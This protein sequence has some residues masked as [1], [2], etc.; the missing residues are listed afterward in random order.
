MTSAPKE[1]MGVVSALTNISRTTGFS[2][3]IAT[4]TSLFTILLGIF[5]LTFVYDVA[6]LNAYQMTAWLFTI[7]VIIAMI[8]SAF[9]GRS[10]SEGG[11]EIVCNPLI[12]EE[13]EESI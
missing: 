10:P 8:A 12:V 3:A 9:R 1:Y 7:F 13:C 11:E 5:Q 2:V 6:Y 4:V